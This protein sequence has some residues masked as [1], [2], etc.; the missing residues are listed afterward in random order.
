[1]FSRRQAGR[2]GNGDAVAHARRKAQ[3]PGQRLHA[4]QA[5]ADDG[6]QLR[7]A[8]TVHQSRLRID[9]VFDR[10]HRKVGAVGPV[11]RLRMRAHRPGAA[12]ARAGVV[13]ADDEQLVGVQRLARAD[14]VVPPADT[15]VRAF[16]APGDM[17]AGIERMAHQHRVAARGVQRAVGLVDQGVVAQRLAALQR[18]RLGEEHRLGTDGTDRSHGLMNDKPGAASLEAVTGCPSLAAFDIAPA[19][20][21]NRRCR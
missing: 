18:Q 8:Q 19:I 11:R 14:Q 13:D 17:V 21:T 20:R 15:V 4:A 16:V 9:P 5:A 12:E 6:S 3:R 1:M 2:G 7:D 10:H